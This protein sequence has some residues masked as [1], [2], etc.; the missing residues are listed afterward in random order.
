MKVLII[1]P[2]LHSMGGHHYTAVQ[3]LQA[4][5][6]Q[7]GIDAPCLGSVFA[8]RQVV[9][10]LA[11]TP[12]FTH[13]VYGRTYATPAEFGISVEGTLRELARAM[14]WRTTPD[15]IVLPCCDQVLA[16]ALARNLR[17]AWS[18]M[19]PRVLLWLLYGPHHLKRPDDPSV[20]D[21]AAESRDALAALAVSAGEVSGYCETR[22]MAAFYRRLVPFEIGIMPGPALPARARAVKAANGPPVVACIGFANRPKGY[23]LL[24]EAA[25]HVLGHHRNVRF[26]IHGVVDGSDA[27]EDRPV[28][29]LLAGMGERVSVRRDRLAPSEYLAWLAEA[30][31]VL[32]PYDPEVY[33]WRGSGVFT[34]A[35]RAGTPVVAPKECA[36]AQ[37]AFD[38]GWGVAMEDYDGKGLGAAVLKALDRLDSLRARAAWAAAQANDDLGLVLR[39]ALERPAPRPLPIPA[40]LRRF[41]PRSA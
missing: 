1:D 33:R 15:L 37:Q 8:D 3:R 31:L 39:S 10:E 24:P 27:E 35:Q 7:L 21:L 23:R 5:L 32:L 9:D 25:R 13:S 18:T 36:F 28:F 11:C 26:M 14:R 41:G 22:E 16:T 12:T 2:A 17:A 34:D 19:R 20:A 29:D 40:I 6:A 38:D 4:E 30:D